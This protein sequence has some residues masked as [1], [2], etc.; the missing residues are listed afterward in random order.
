MKVLHKKN[1]VRQALA[2]ARAAGSRIGLVPTMGFFHE[3]HLSL[4]RLCRSKCDLCVVSIFINP[5]QFGPQEDFA[6][7]PRDPQR[8]RAMAEAESVDLVFAPAVKEMYA[9]DASTTVMEE[10]VSRGLCGRSRPGHFRGVTTVVAKLFNVVQPDVAFF[11]QKDLQQLAVIRRMVRDLDLP[12]I[13][14]AGP[15]VRE[16]D[17]LALSSRNIY[18]KPDERRRAPGLYRA[19]CKGGQMFSGAKGNP[20]PLLE[21]I[22]RQIESS[23]GGK[24]E[25]LSGVDQDI[26]EVADASECRYLAAALH[27]GSTRLIDNVGIA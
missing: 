18:L 10:T 27:F 6:G 13:I 25:Y 26:K 1:Q 8:D 19:L 9:P 14:E 21:E 23:T 24:V 16:P 11:G 7:Y 3:G 17:G 5:T 20:S 12:V 15:I 2:R 4:M 22:S